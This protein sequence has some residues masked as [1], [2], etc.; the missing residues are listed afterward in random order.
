MAKRDYVELFSLEEPLF[1][2]SYI[3]SAFCQNYEIKEDR[4]SRNLIPR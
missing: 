3:F 1:L 4:N 2:D